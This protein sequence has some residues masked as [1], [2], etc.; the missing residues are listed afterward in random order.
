MERQAK[1]LYE[2][3]VDFKRFATILLAAGVFFYLGIIIPSTTKN[4]M[5]LNIM[6]LASIA[7]LA[8]SIFLFSRSK[9]YKKELLELDDAKELMK[10]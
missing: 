3:M 8:F 6:S 4:T 9:K 10:K 7:F 1:H 5:E 2:K